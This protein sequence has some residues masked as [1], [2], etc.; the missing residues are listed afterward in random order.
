MQEVVLYGQTDPA[1]SLDLSYQQLDG[2]N[3]QTSAQ[4]TPAGV[5]VD[6][7]DIGGL[8]LVCQEGGIY[9]IDVQIKCT[10]PSVFAN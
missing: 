3:V 2:F 4:L 7:S 6:S 9:K 1:L 10:A 8:R 5:P